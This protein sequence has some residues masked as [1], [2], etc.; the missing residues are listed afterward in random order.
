MANLPLQDKISVSSDES[1][2]IKLL[3]SDFG[4][5][6]QQRSADGINNTVKLLS[7]VHEF[8]EST[9]A[10]TLRTFY[11]NN[12]AGQIVTITGPFDA[13]NRNYFLESYAETATQGGT[14]RSFTANFRQVYDT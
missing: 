2:N 6:Y 4:D 9:D 1:V 8:L 12:S 3:I 5:G 7:I 13:T 14:L 11:Q 10:G